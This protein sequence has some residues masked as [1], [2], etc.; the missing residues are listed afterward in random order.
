MAF[1]D[2]LVNAL[3]PSKLKSL[4]NERLS[5]LIDKEAVRARASL[6]ELQ[7]RYPSAGPRELS[8]RLIDSKKQVASMLGGVTGIFGAVTVPVDLVGMVYLQLV[9]LVEVGT[10]FKADFK[11]E[12]GKKDVLDLFGYANGIGPVQRA[13]PKVLGSLAALVLTKTGLKAIGRAMPLVAAPI[14][15]Y[16]NNQ[17]VQR[18]G[19]SA[20]RHYDGWVHAHEKSKKA[21]GS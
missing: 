18:V 6:E 12:R 3:S 8:Q 11:N 17:H 4:A 9:L 15:A 2:P 20:I 5:D 7:Q 1:Y 21:S 19:D 10:V 14:S 13:S 16:L